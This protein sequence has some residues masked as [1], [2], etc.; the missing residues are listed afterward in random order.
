M[1]YLR[2]FRQNEDGV[3]VIE[4]ILIL[5]V[6]IAL[7]LLFKTQLTSLVKD[8]LSKVASQSKAI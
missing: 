7:V 5:L 2:Q 1:K 4:I 8:I 3:A 6:L